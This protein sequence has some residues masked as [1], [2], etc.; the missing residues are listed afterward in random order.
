MANYTI[1]GG[2]QKEYG[3]I[4]GDDLR[5][6][7]AEG[8][9]NEQSLA[10]GEGDAEFRPLE[11]FP[12]LA[13]AFAPKSSTSGVPPP[14]AEHLPDDPNWQAEV[15]TRVPELRLGEC[16]AAGWSFLAVNAGFLVGAVV[17]TWVVNLF[18][19][20]ISLAVPLL[21][22]IIYL[23][24]SGVIMGGFYLACLRRM[25]GETVSPTEVFAGFKIAFVP[26]LLTGLISALL[27]EVSICFCILPAIYLFIAWIFALPLVADKKLFFWS[28]MEL[29]RKIVTRVWFEVF[30][31]VIIAFLPMVI[32]QVFNM[33]QTG[34]F[35]FNLYAQANHNWQQLA[36]DIPNHTDELRNLTIKMTLAGQ[37][38][39]LIT[40]FY[41]VGALMRAYENLFGP[42][43]Q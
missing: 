14:L 22:P 28:A 1:I 27:T 10:K 13:A 4:S 24:I 9:L 6:W 30:A 29:S 41:S 16:L 35:V 19:V 23:C 38:A 37:V 8:R 15:T 11:K 18:F 33:I 32:F 2:D 3:P 25:R 42:R 26:L 39:L 40:L 21:G 17:L 12:E 43:K 36:Q 5:Q 34:N 20:F 31:L 7:I